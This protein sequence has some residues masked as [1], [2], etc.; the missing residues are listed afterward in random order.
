MRAR[1]LLSAATTENSDPRLR[2]RASVRERPRLSDWLHRVLCA[3]RA[4]DRWPLR[5][6]WG[7]LCGAH[8]HEKSLIASQLQKLQ[9]F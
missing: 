9:S 6:S 5:E 1:A 3:T 2:R 8:D 7:T 4:D